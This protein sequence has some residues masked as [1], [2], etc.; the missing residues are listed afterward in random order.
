MRCCMSSRCSSGCI[1]VRQ[2][3]ANRGGRQRRTLSLGNGYA[4]HSKRV[5]G[6]PASAALPTSGHV[7]VIGA[8]VLV[9]IVPDA[10]G[11]RLC[12][13]G[14]GL[15]GAGGGQAQRTIQSRRPTG[16]PTAAMVSTRAITIPSGA[17]RDGEG[18]Q[19]RGGSGGRRPTSASMVECVR[20]VV[21]VRSVADDSGRSGRRRRAVMAV[22]KGS[23]GRGPSKK[24][25]I[26]AGWHVV[27]GPG[28]DQA[29]RRLRGSLFA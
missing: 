26:P 9:H 17:P 8:P 28:F 7:A 19:G 22:V 23:S 6:G 10:R 15:A 16:G 29:E 20:S 4:V 2:W 14:G 11:Q 1:A 5:V 12:F 18:K 13:A 25:R 3:Q 21:S 24:R 27:P